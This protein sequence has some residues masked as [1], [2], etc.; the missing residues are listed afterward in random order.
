MSAPPPPQNNP[1]SPSEPP[2]QSSDTPRPKN[3]TKLP[4]PDQVAEAAL[5]RSQVKDKR[6]TTRDPLENFTKD[7]TI[8]IQD[9]HPDVAYEF[10]DNQTIQEWD[11]LEG[12]KL[13][14]IP[15]E[16][17]ACNPELN[18]K[19]SLQIFSAV[20]AITKSWTVGV[21]TPL[22]SEELRRRNRMPNIFLIHNLTE[23][24]YQILTQQTVWASQKVTFRVKPTDMLCPTF[25][26]AI[27]D[28]RTLD[29]D[30]VRNTIRS[31]WNDQTT[32][33]FFLSA[34]QNLDEDARTEILSSIQQFL[35]SVHVTRLDTRDEG[36]TLR[37]TFNVYMD[38]TLMKDINSW[39]SIRTHLVSRQYHSTRLGQGKAVIAPYHCG[40]CHSVDHPKGLCPFPSI[41]GWNGP[42]GRK[43]ANNNN[44]NNRAGPSCNTARPSRNRWN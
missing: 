3:R 44:N 39:S 26:F 35:D 25:M 4:N 9:A 21:A 20:A 34:V 12:D 8:V 32:S 10:L 5:L 18:E 16:N 15:F 43:Q 1:A 7:V 19:I 14:A 30:L 13:F 28:L 40:L 11:A 2:T 6:A 24:H 22:P 42:R 37:P 27:R 29:A 23:M 33:Q 17:D 36:A 31:L 38:A 41:E